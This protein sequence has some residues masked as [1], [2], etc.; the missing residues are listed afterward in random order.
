MQEY[1]VLQSDTTHGLET[2][3]R[4]ALNESEMTLFGEPLEFGGRKCQV[5]VK[6]IVTPET[7]GG[8]DT[9]EAVLLRIATAEMKAA[10]AALTASEAKGAAEV[11]A[12]NLATIT[13]EVSR[14]AD[15]ASG[16]VPYEQLPEFPVGRKVN[17]A[18]KAARLALAGYTDLTIAYQS[19]T[20][21]AWGLDANA[22]ASVEANWS[23][24]GNAQATGVS[25]FNGR[26]GNIGP[27]Q[28]DY[29][30]SMIPEALGKRYVTEEQITA[31]NAKPGPT[32]IA[33]AINQALAGGDLP[34]ETK[35]HASDTYVTK[36]SRGA[37]NGVAPLGV[38]NKIPAIHLPV[39]A[40][41]GEWVIPVT[42]YRDAKSAR[43]ALQW[44]T[45]TTAY[46][47]DVHICMDFRVGQG[48]S[49]LE[50]RDPSL[51]IYTINATRV[52]SNAT[53]NQIINAAIPSGWSYRLTIATDVARVV[54]RWYEL[55]KSAGSTFVPVS[56]KGIANGVAPLDAGSRVPVGNLPAFLPQS[57]RVWRDVKST[58]S[59]G[60]WVTNTSPN[61]ME[62]HARATYGAVGNR[63]ISLQTRESS[64]GTTFVFNSTVLNPLGTTGLN[65]ADAS[66]VTVPA[67]WQYQISSTGGSTDALIERWYELS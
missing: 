38:D 63:F 56:Q 11:A 31:W 46:D 13:L 51:N 29:I 41:G 6:G 55:D 50:V 15:L 52:G 53:T 1:K 21:D 60:A 66:T 54:E 47:R 62:V 18:D 19:D 17:V 16:K 30:T 27:Q 5:V 40:G 3:V 64:T 61:E 10:Q 65:Y 9:P 2:M 45:N 32:E 44:Y 48:L 20:G 25:S 39:I 22:D 34:F 24:L 37:A 28:G 8:N 57:K 43:A 42:T 26:T 67:G 35:Q 49:F 36:D 33:A 7:P 58:R 14:K 12:A 23:R 4:E 59:V